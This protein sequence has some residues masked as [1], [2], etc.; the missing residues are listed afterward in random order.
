[1]AAITTL[2]PDL[3][4]TTE[5]VDA[6]SH[7]RVQILNGAATVFAQDGYEGASMSRIATEAGVSKGTLYNYFSCK[8]ELFAEYVQLKCS[9]RVAQVFD[10]LDY[11]NSPAETLGRIGRRMVAMLVSESALV[12]HRMVVAEAEKFPELAQSFYQAGPEPAVAHLA[13]YLQHA[14][15]EGW[16]AV[17]D[18]AF[19]AEQFFALIQARLY[20]KRQLR[21]ADIPSAA[22][23]DHVV[24]RAVWLFLRGYAAED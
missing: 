16:L 8:A 12:M 14:S 4:L 24:D 7:K 6:G 17:P 3:G 15:A 2:P 11:A 10:N 19:G 18:A 20:L 21:L 13:A 22:Q 9:S 23:I 1:M 5:G